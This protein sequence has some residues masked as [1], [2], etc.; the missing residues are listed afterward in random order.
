MKKED[1]AVIKF[2][3]LLM[4]EFEKGKMD[5]YLM[6]PKSEKS[7]KQLTTPSQL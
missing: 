2:L 4:R 3:D 7:E 5:D 1:T 6:K